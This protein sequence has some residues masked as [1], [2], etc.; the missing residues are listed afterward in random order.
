M[1][2]FLWGEGCKFRECISTYIL[3]YIFSPSL[4]PGGHVGSYRKSGFGDGWDLGLNPA[5]DLEL[6]ELCALD[7]LLSLGLSF[8]VCTMGFM[9]L[10]SWGVERMKGEDAGQ[11]VTHLMLSVIS[12]TV[13]PHLSHLFS[14]PGVVEVL[15]FSQH[16]GWIMMD[17]MWGTSNNQCHHCVPV[18]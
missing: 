5:S 13:L 4:F 7:K 1:F 16:C 2:L 12:P 10:T 15:T 11:S 9:V 3:N 18:I 17:C 8:L 14:F 6:S